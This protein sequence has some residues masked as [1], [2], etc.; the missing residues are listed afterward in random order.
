MG[1][2]PGRR[3][4]AS[5][6]LVGEQVVPEFSC[7]FQ[8]YRSILLWIS[9]LS[10]GGALIRY[11]YVDLGPPPPAQPRGCAH[12]D[13]GRAAGSRCDLVD[14]PVRR[15]PGRDGGAGRAGPVGAGRGPGRCGGRGRPRELGK[16][17]LAYG[18][19][20]DWLT[21]L[22]G[23]RKGEGRR[24]VA[25]AHALTG[26]LE[27][28]PG[29]D[30]RR[31]RVTR[32]GRRHREVDRPVAVGD[33]G[34][35]PRRA[36]SPGARR[37]RSMPP[38]S[39]APGGTWSTWS[40]PTPP[41][42]SSNG[43]WTGRNAPPTTPATCPSPPMVPAESASRAAA[44]PRTAPCSKQRLL[45][46]T[47][48]APAP[49][50]RRR[51]GSWCTI[52]A[53]PVPGCGTPWSAWPSTRWTPTCHPTPTAHPPGWWSPP[54]WTPCATGLQTGLADTA[55]ERAVRRHHPAAGL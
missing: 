32:A 50:R 43:S 34:P 45:P 52:R 54:P 10:V 29:G 51:T 36:D 15:R 2:V 27:A 16:T 55:V 40:T 46:L 12:A 18:S 21:H 47:A 41:T 3:C 6:L 17:K 5:G 22:G 26:P 42:A 11:S 24:I 25:R 20:G 23:L 44:P 53:M 9:G 49:E 37:W 31:D 13:G 48:P 39:P 4:R 28:H 14:E 7:S 33:R 1:F 35:R 38:T 30:G 8:E 19:T